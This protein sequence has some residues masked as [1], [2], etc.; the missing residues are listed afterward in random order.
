MVGPVRV[1][2]VF[3]F[4]QRAVDLGEGSGKFDDLVELLAVRPVG[5]FDVAVQLGGARRQNEEP[6]AA[7]PAGDLELGMNSEPPST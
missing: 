1:V 5:A 4:S 3:P 2:D 6:E 7:V